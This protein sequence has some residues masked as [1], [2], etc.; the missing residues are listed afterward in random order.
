MR[1]VIKFSLLSALVVGIVAGI[2]KVA[3]EL[4]PVLVEPHDLL[5][6]DRTQSTSAKRTPEDEN[7]STKSKLRF[8]MDVNDPLN[9]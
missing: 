6:K 2:R 8:N 1:K 3:R 4:G 9:L 5:R 7:E